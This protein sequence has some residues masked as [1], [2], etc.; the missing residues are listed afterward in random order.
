MARVRFRIA[1]PNTD[2]ASQIQEDAAAAT[3]TANADGS[4]TYTMKYAVPATAKG[5]YTL[6]VEGYRNFTILPGT[7]QGADRPRFRPQQDAG[8]LG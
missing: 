4:Y 3:V 1:G 7:E 2:W 5:S 6:G 8:L